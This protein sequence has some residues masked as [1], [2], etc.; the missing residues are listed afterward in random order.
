[1][2]AS[3]CA[4]ACFDNANDSVPHAF[5]RLPEERHA[6]AGENK[7]TMKTISIPAFGGPEQLQLLELPQPRPAA[8]EVL[9]KLE[10][11]GLNFIDIYMR[12]GNSRA[13]KPTQPRYR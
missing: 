11:A 8:G 6:I 7:D 13:R 1:M 3:A 5:Q 10:Y 9:V 2:R 4:R 12:S